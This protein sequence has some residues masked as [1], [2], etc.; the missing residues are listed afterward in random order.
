MDIP[1]TEI[2]YKSK[3]VRSRFYSEVT[4]EEM[5]T[6]QKGLQD[7]PNLDT[8]K[9]ALYDVYMGSTDCSVTDKYYIQDL[10]YQ[11]QYYGSIASI[12]EVVTDKRWDTK[13]SFYLWGWV[14]G[15]YFF[16]VLS[17]RKYE[18]GKESL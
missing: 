14:N 10:L 4:D 12:S 9:R 15:R 6:I 1:V 13:S 18:V 8:V 17:D 2:E 11:V 16:D 5:D 7:S 3:K